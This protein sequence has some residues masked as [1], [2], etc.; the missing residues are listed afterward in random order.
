[1]VFRQNTIL[2]QRTTKYTVW[3]GY[4][5][6]LYMHVQSNSS[7]IVLPAHQDLA[8][9][10]DLFLHHNVNGK[11]LLLLESNDLMDMGITSVG[12][13]IDIKVTIPNKDYHLQVI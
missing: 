6:Q 4:N 8:Q 12:H 3:E 5:A 11:R 7:H 13:K 1:M 9:Y 10:A 2:K